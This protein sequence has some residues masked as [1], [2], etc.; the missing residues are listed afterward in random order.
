MSRKDYKVIAE[1]FSELH[2][3]HCPNSPAAKAL[4]R[5]R[6]KVADIF[7]ADNPRFDRGKFNVACEQK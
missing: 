3:K 5:V 6:D 2:K 4:K 1:V 7:E